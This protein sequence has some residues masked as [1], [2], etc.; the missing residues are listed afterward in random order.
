MNHSILF[1][2][3]L[4][5]IVD[6]MIWYASNKNERG[7][8]SGSGTLNDP[9]TLSFALSSHTLL[10]AGDTLLL[11]DGIYR[12]SMSTGRNSNNNN[13]KNRFV[14]KGFGGK[15]GLPIVIRSAR[16]FNVTLDGFHSIDDASDESPVLRILCPYTIWH[17]LSITHSNYELLNPTLH[18]NSNCF[19][20]GVLSIC[21]NVFFVVVVVVVG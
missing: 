19:D 7:V 17:G 8:A 12:P 21:S 11:M 13:N 16:G 10:R 3:S 6:C 9:W 14:C 4:L 15:K 5:S 18:K 20:C 1:F 2:I